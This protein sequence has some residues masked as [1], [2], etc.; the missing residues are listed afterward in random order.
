MKSGEFMMG[1]E[2]RGI[3][4]RDEVLYLDFVSFRLHTEET[5]QKHEEECFSKSYK[6]RKASIYFYTW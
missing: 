2:G 6:E 4:G 5:D 3:E 1:L